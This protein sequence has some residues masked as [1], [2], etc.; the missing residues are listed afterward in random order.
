MNPLYR[1]ALLMGASLGCCLTFAGAAQSAVLWDTLT[2]NSKIGFSSQLDIPTE[3]AD[4]FTVTGNGFTVTDVSFLGLFSDAD[5]EIEDI[6]MAFYSVFP[7]ASDLTRTPAT[8]RENGPEDE[9]FVAFSLGE[10][11][12]SF[13]SQDLGSFTL[14]QTILPSSGPNA[15]GVGSGAVG[16]P[17]T[18]NLRQIDVKLKNPLTLAPDAVFLVNAVD[19]STGEYFQVAGDRPP[20][21]PN[22]LPEGVIDRQAWFRTN[23]PFPNALE[24]DW[25]RISDVVNQQDGT[26]DPAF[27]SAF[28]VSGEEVAVP[29]PGTV[30]LFSLLLLSPAAVLLR[31]R[32]AQKGALS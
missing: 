3:A 13:S 10:D 8:V 12:L 26:A 6:N 27:N 19:P 28:R 20:E 17:L 23:E 2:P 31:R 24:P 29:E 32:K 30:S 18:G 11:T 9:E 21:F 22:P 14:D 15:P 5:A 16:G 25:V 7:G 4:D 1:S